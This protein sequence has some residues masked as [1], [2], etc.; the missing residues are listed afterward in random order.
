MS[1]E[2]IHLVASGDSLGITKTMWACGEPKQGEKGNFGFPET[3]Y[4]INCEKCKKTK[5]YKEQKL[6]VKK[7]KEYPLVDVHK[8]SDYHDW[9]EELRGATVVGVMEGGVKSTKPIALKLEKDKKFYWCE[10]KKGD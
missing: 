7:E 9:T 5:L 8:A 3:F 1:E 4:Q 2:I 10:L 6:A